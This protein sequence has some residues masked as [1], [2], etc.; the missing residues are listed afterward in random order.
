M[1]GLRFVGYRNNKLNRK[2]LKEIYKEAFPREEKIPF[3]MLKMLARGSRGE[4]YGVYDQ[5]ELAGLVY[6]VHY[7][8]IIYISYLAVDD[9]K[10]GSGY[11][12][13]ILQ[14]IQK[15]YSDSRI[16]LC[17]EE[18]DPN[19]ENYEQRVRRKAFYESN[20]FKMLPFQV[21]E[22][23]VMYDS[24]CV[25]DREPEIT[26]KECDELMKHYFG[27]WTFVIYVKKYTDKIVGLFDGK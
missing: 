18:M 10:R 24:M 15:K 16:F 6:N 26:R 13:R 17:I 14:T 7:K 9:T 4:F 5:D 22:G 8:D 11:G 19:A 27:M 21:K 12:S 2:G 23:I 3:W 25:A 20:G 1:S